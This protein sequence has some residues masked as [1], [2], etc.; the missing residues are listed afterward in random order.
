MADFLALCGQNS[1]HTTVPPNSSTR[2]RLPP[3]NP[4]RM[5]MQDR[6]DEGN[7]LCS[8]PIGRKSRSQPL[9]KVV[10]SAREGKPRPIPVMSDKKRAP[11]SVS[12]VREARDGDG[13]VCGKKCATLVTDAD[14]GAFRSRIYDKNRRQQNAYIMAEMRAQGRYNEPLPSS[15]SSDSPTCLPWRHGNFI[16]GKRVRQGSPSHSKRAQLLVHRASLLI[17]CKLT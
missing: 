8:V 10:R 9:V 2:A 7:K 5:G 13:C 1:P 12:A 3:R 11:E 4:L 14:I 15:D 6:D 17:A 16:A